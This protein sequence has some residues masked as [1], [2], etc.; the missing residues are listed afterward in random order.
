MLEE[1]LRKIILCCVVWVLGGG[2][3]VRES[4]QRDYIAHTR[5]KIR[6]PTCSAYQ[7]M[8][9]SHIFCMYLVLCNTNE[10]C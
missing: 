7:H 8:I 2:G 1:I 5:T 3:V 9:F 10:M 6:F 4:G